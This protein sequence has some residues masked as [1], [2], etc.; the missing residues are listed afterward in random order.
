MDDDIVKVGSG[1]RSS[2]LAKG[3]RTWVF[4]LAL[5]FAMASASALH[6]NPYLANRGNAPLS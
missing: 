4:M 1:Q 2:P 5:L 6:A 3:E